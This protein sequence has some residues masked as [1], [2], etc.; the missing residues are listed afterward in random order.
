M[1]GYLCCRLAAARTRH[2]L[3][4][5]TLALPLFSFQ[6]TGCPPKG[7]MTILGQPGTSVKV[8]NSP[9]TATPPAR[10]PPARRARCMGLLDAATFKEP[11]GVLVPAARRPPPSIAG[12][13]R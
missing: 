13:E 11:G 4:E 9:K 2:E 8:A 3:K 10:F 6:R 5:Q 12:D 1:V 7:R